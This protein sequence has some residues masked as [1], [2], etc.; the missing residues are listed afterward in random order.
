MNTAKFQAIHCVVANA[1][2][3]GVVCGTSHSSGIRTFKGVGAPT[4]ST[5]AFG[6]GRYNG[7]NSGF[8]Y[9]VNLFAGGTGNN[10]G[11]V[12][13]LGGGTFT[14]AAKVTVDAVEGG[15][16]T[17]WHISTV[18][19][20]SVYPV[21]AWSVTATTGSGS[22][23]E[24]NFNAPPPDY[25]IDVTTPTAPVLYICNTGG[26]NATSVWNKVTGSGGGLI[27][28]YDASGGT[29]YAGGSIV[30]VASQFTLSGI[31][32]Q[33]GTY[34]L[35]SSL[36]VPAS[37]TGNQI[38]Q[39]PVPATGTIYWIPLAAGLVVAS[40]CATGTTETIYVNATG[41]F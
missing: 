14:T 6:N 29:A 32:V 8:I 11:D 25:Y 31:V 5:L 41:Q 12:L 10:V 21:G 15:V 22:G 1:P 19:V 17:D 35:L 33:P 36:S 16:I 26:T 34:G 7:V 39:I 30:I 40:T 13:T 20:Y 27:A 24:F 2:A 4:S 38:P 23:A 18:G 3:N 37:P 28:I 9:S